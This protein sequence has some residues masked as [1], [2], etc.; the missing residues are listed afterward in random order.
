M[1]DRQLGWSGVEERQRVAAGGRLDGFGLVAVQPKGSAGGVGF[2]PF[3][4]HGRL[5]PSRT[6]ERSP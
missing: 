2:G 4:P 3:G 6:P 5:L 1:G